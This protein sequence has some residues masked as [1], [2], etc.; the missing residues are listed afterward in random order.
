MSRTIW[1]VLGVIAAVV[2]AWFLVDLVFSVLWFVVKLAIV[3]VVAVV[4]FLWL[5]SLV[6]RRDG[7]RAVER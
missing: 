7:R 1:T 4:V 3:A 5:R 2:I 6:A